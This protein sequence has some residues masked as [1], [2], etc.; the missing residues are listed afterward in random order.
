[1]SKRAATHQA[2]GSAQKMNPR[3]AEEQRQEQLKQEAHSLA[4][5][6][7]AVVPA[8]LAELLQELKNHQA[9]PDY[10]RNDDPDESEDS[11]EEVYQIVTK[12]PH[13]MEQFIKKLPSRGEVFKGILLDSKY[14]L[15]HLFSIQCVSPFVHYI[16]FRLLLPLQVC[17]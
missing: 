1:M 10:Y 14:Y 3:L 12:V 16:I 13:N 9:D 11:S 15:L 2:P 5:R 4:Q 17:E 8:A 6:A 7:H